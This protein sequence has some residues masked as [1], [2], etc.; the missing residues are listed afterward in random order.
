MLSC[1]G[2]FEILLPAGKICVPESAWAILRLVF[3]CACGEVRDPET[4][5]RDSQET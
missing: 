5:Q 4:K 2:L 3:F 1:N